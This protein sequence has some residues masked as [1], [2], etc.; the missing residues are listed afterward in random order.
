MLRKVFVAYSI[1]NEKKKD[2]KIN[3]PSVYFK[4][5]EKGQIKFQVFKRKIVKFRAEMNKIENE[6]SIEKNQ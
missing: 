1:Y 3:H 4:K 5:L 6:K 2:L